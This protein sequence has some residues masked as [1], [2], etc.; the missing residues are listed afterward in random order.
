[1]KNNIKKMIKFSDFKKAL[2]LTLVVTLAVSGFF[3]LVEPSMTNAATTATVTVSLSVTA[4]VA[5]TVDS[6]TSA[7]STAITVSQNTA[8]ATSTF[9]VTTNDY[10]GYNLNLTASVA[11]A[12][13]SASSTIPDVTTTPT[14]Y[15]A[16]IPSNSYGFGFSAYSTTNPT[17][18][19]TATWGTQTT[20][21]AN[22]A[23][24]PSAGLK[25][26]GFNSS[27]PILVASNTSTTTTSG[28]ATI[29]C[30]MVGQNGSYI[31][32]GSYT[33][34]ITATASTK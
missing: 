23:N 8:V 25:Y 20:G 26:R 19:P 16:V 31:P 15:P 28:N 24:V 27:T 5:V 7:M 32:S 10:L 34:T 17:D 2:G 14:L 30:F 1:L 12:M 4:G 33:A 3:V 9:T 13:Q 22:G 11:P 6:S 18:V 21:C 29:V